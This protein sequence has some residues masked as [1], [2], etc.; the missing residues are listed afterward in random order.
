MLVLSRMKDETI[1]VG[2]DIEITIVAIGGKHV[3]VGIDAPAEMAVHRKEV[4]DAIQQPKML[5]KDEEPA[6]D[7]IKAAFKA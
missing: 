3:R 5:G 4:Y 2:D 1:M 7:A 6:V